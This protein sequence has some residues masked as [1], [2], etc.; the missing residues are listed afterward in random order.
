LVP[1]SEHFKKK[2]YKKHL[3]TSIVWSLIFCSEVIPYVKNQTKKTN[4][5]SSFCL[6]FLF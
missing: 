5:I 6:T 2:F 3:K 1:L 4:C